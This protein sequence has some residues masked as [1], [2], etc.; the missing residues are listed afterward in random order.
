MNAYQQEL[1]LNVRAKRRRNDPPAAR[2]FFALGERL[3]REV[4]AERMQKTRAR[5]SH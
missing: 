2:L 3:R 5:L 1:P 4:Q